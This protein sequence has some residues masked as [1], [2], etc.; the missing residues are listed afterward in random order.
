M[1]ITLLMIGKT[2]AAYIS[3]GMNEYLNRL[4][5]YVKFETIVI[6]DVRKGKN[7]TPE[8]QKSQEG[9]LI[10]AK[11]SSLAEM[12][13]F[14]E[15]GKLFTSRQFAGFIEKKQVAGT[16]EL[17]FVIGGP[18]GFSQKVYENAHSRISL[19]KMTFSHQM[20][21]LLCVEQIY[22]AYTI[23]NGEPYHHD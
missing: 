6:P 12:H 8:M 4:K 16:R 3:E 23:I 7:T 5:H 22:R 10:L 18:Y 21:R 14:D 1:K 13:L 19:S 2:D 20:A 17:I 15:N 9:E 11:K